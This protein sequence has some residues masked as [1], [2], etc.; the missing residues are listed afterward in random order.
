[1]LLSEP[2]QF[3]ELAQDQFQHNIFITRRA[4]QTAPCK[5]WGII[6]GQKHIAGIY[7]NST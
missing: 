3:S 4:T 1:M 5:N 2:G 7:L 6:H